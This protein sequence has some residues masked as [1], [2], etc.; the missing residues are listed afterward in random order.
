MQLGPDVIVFITMTP[1]VK[2]VVRFG[3]GLHAL[4]LP[5][6]GRAALS[7]AVSALLSATIAVVAAARSA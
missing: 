6:I 2:V 4:D 1:I 5:M 3:L 7:A